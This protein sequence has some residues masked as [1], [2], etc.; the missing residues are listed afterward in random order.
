M[1]RSDFEPA[2]LLIRTDVGHYRA[3]FKRRD[4]ALA[5]I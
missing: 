1:T 5:S 3:V 4:Q 2:L